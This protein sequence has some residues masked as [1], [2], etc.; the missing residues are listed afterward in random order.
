MTDAYIIRIKK[1]FYQPDQGTTP[2]VG[3]WQ[4]SP[5]ELRHWLTEQDW[6]VHQ[7]EIASFCNAGFLFQIT[8]D[9][10][11]SDEITDILGI[12]LDEFASYDHGGNWTDLSRS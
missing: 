2:I 1:P 4:G 8:H 6:P 12:D 7:Y 9:P 11:R 5:Q 10:N 3:I